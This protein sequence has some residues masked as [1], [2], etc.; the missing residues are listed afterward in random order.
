MAHKQKQK[1]Q[2]LYLFQKSMKVTIQIR[3]QTHWSAK[4][5][6]KIIKMKMKEKQ[7]FKILRVKILQY[8]VHQK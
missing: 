4:T 5:F 2:P 1:N 3:L 6:M 7:I 8:M